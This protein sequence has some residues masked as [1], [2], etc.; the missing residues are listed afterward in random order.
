LREAMRAAL[1]A[2]NG[3]G[4]GGNNHNHQ[5]NRTSQPKPAPTRRVDHEQN[6]PGGHRCD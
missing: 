1:D 5:S 2:R 3:N 6:T 4:N